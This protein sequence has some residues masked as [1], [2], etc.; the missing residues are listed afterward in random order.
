MIEEASAPVAVI[1]NLD[2]RVKIVV[3]FF[4]SVLV[5]VSERFTVLG[6]ALAA[7]LIIIIAAG[8]PFKKIARRLIPVNTLVL[9]LWLFLPF[10]FSGDPLF[11]VWGLTVTR[12]G[13]LQAARISI[14]SNTIMLMLIA[15]VMST[16][17]FKLGHAMHELGLPK[18]LVHLLFFTYRY[19]HVIYHEYLRLVNAMKIRCF[20]PGT[21]LHTY[22]TVAYMLGML[23]VK[24][25][26]RGQRVHNAM[27]CRGFKG[28]FY[29]LSEFSLEKKDVLCVVVMAV[30]IVVLGVLE[31]T[32][33]I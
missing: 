3:V 20:I 7:D 28:D 31:W 21:N 30:L 11:T 1:G 32:A 5:A 29:S 16:S 2:P 27:R 6:L 22:R 33:T 4:F 13:V 14:K 17:I 26:D 15:L 18:K 23:L 10:T 19:I 9:L 12:Q 8:I 24:S 25:A